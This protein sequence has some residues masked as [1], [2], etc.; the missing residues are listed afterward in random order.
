MPCLTHL[1]V[2]CLCSSQSHP[3]PPAGIANVLR[4]FKLSVSSQTGTDWHRKLYWCLWTCL[5]K[6]RKD[7]Q[8]TFKGFFHLAVG[9][10]VSL[11]VVIPWQLEQQ[12]ILSCSPTNGNISASQLCY[13]Y[14]IWIMTSDLIS[15]PLHLHLNLSNFK[16]T[17]FIPILPGLWSG[18]N[19]DKHG[20]SQVKGGK[21][22]FIFK[23]LLAKEDLLATAA[24]CSPS[25]AYFYPRRKRRV[26]WSFNLLG[27]VFLSSHVVVHFLSCVRATN[28]NFSEGLIFFLTL[29]VCVLCGF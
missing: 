18:L 10:L 4:G 3:G 22:V 12:N 7:S 13:E 28:P 25:S 27:R 6:Q 1:S 24:I 9:V 19:I 17:F 20:A 5:R 14:I 11:F 16:K 23:S 2:V 29:L 21:A 15:G 26:Q 8:S